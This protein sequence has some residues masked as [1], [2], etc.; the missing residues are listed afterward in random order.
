[1]L[2]NTCKY[3]VRAVIY[4]GFHYEAGKRIG[5]KQISDDLDIPMPFLGKVLQ[6]LAK[7]KLLLSSKGPHGGFGLGKGGMGLTLYDIV[8]AVD[9][10][11]IFCNC[12]IGSHRCKEGEKSCPVHDQY[13]SIRHD[14]VT[15]FKRETVGEIVSKMNDPNDFMR[16]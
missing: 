16:L 8:E 7:K 11:D 4:L 10:S 1:M 9:G 12:L 3:A 15:F 13:H 14:F 5:I 6:S 2:S